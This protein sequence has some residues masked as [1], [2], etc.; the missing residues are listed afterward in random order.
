MKTYRVVVWEIDIDADSPV[1][2]AIK[3]LAIQ[4]DQN[5][6]ALVFEVLGERKSYLVDLSEEG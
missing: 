5:S 4:R 2:A 1:M 6:I 3:A